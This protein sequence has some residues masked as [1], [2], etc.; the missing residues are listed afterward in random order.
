MRKLHSHNTAPAGLIFFLIFPPA[1][2]QYT[3][4]KQQCATMVVCYYFTLCQPARNDD[5]HVLVFPMAVKFLHL[6]LLLLLFL[7]CTL[8]TQTHMQRIYEC[9]ARLTHVQLWTALPVAKREKAGSARCTAPSSAR[10][11]TDLSSRI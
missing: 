11:L 2:P 7:S 9:I 5:D 10:A 3:S 8:I 4:H 6:Q 1:T